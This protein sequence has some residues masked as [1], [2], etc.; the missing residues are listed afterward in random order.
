MLYFIIIN[1]FWWGPSA[2]ICILG[3]SPEVLTR[4]VGC[5]IAFLPFGYS[6]AAKHFS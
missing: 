5:G 2:E 3:E 4:T 1:F 6:V